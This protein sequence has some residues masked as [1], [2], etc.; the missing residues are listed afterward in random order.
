MNLASTSFS[1]RIMNCITDTTFQKKRILIA[2]SLNFIQNVYLPKSELDL[3]FQL[4]ELFDKVSYIYLCVEIISVPSEYTDICCMLY[5]LLQSVQM[6][7]Y[8][9]LCL[10][11][12]L[13]YVNNIHE[14]LI[15]SKVKHQFN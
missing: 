6:K 5:T 10:F 8:F 14:V 12:T 7:T 11:L 15:S 2:L 9:K 4:Y 13:P 3:G 1:I